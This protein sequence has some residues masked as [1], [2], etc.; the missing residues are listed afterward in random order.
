[1]WNGQGKA[2]QR[3]LVMLLKFQRPALAKCA[4]SCPMWTL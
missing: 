4:T 2:K 1:V 3:K